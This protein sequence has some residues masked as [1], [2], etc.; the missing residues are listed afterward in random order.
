MKQEA[1]LPQRQECMWL[2]RPFKVTQ[3]HLMLFQMTRLTVVMP[4]TT[5]YMTYQHSI[6]TRPLPLTILEISRPVCRSI[7]HLSSRWKWKKTAGSRWTCFGVRVSRT[8]DYPIIN[9]NPC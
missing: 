7:P 1:Q 8:L 9:S 4:I 2:K 5:A 6:V 3:G